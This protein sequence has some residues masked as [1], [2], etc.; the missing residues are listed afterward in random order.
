MSKHLRRLK[1]ELWIARGLVMVLGA[2]IGAIVA[3]ALAR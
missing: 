3:A 1:R 2:I